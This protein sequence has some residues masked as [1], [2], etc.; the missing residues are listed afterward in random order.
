MLM[1]RMGFFIAVNL[2]L[3]RDS[4]NAVVVELPKSQKWINN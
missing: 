3:K 1:I 4:V 2:V